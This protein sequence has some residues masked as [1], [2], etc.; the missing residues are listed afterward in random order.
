[1]NCTVFQLLG[2]C[3]VAIRY[4]IIPKN[5]ELELLNAASTGSADFFERLSRYLGE[6]KARVALGQTKTSDGQGGSLALAQVHDAVR[7]D[8]LLGD[9]SAVVATL[10]R[11]LFRT[12]VTWNYG[13]DVPVPNMRFDIEEPVD[14]QALMTATEKAVN[15]GIHDDARQ[16]LRLGG[17][18]PRLALNVFPD[19]NTQ[20]LEGRTGRHCRQK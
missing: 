16:G 7:N 14:L 9:A 10:K 18:R 8:I 5:M 2:N 6:L 4:A 12:V 11:D 17:L 19:A 3:R 15:M 1:M 20:C 13:P